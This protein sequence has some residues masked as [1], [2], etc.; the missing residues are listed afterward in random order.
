MDLARDTHRSELWRGGLLLDM[1]TAD[2]HKYTRGGQLPGGFQVATS[3]GVTLARVAPWALLELDDQDG[4]VGEV[5]VRARSARPGASLML[6]LGG[7]CLGWQRLSSSWRELVFKDV[8]ASPR[9]RKVLELH[10]S[11]S[12]GKGP[13]M[14][15]DWI[16]IK[17]RISATLPGVSR[18]EVG[19]RPSPNGALEARPPERRAYYL[20][21]PAGAAL[22][23]S[24]SASRP[25]RFTVTA[26]R[27]GL[28]P[29]R[30]H[31]STPRS[32]GGEQERLDLAPLAGQMI[33]LELAVS[34][35]GG[36]RKDETGAAT[37]GGP[38]S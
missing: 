4:D 1:G 21:V 25:A 6:A 2:Q 11:R 35:V 28:P 10:Q 33:R 37:W 30:L 29:L 7:H 34:W 17:A 9:G 13:A 19:T 32:Q 3:G 5:V 31:R 38:G 26:H 23:I 12:A 27:D 24:P 36:S 22:F 14:E 20:P 8:P 16:W 15:V 18:V